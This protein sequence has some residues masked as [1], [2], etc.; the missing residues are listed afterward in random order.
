MVEGDVDG[1]L[2]GLADAGGD[3][4]LGR[5]VVADAVEALEVV[6]E[7]LSQLQE[8]VVRGVVGAALVQGA[9]G[10]LGEMAGRVEV[11]LADAEGDDVLH[12]ADE[13][14]EAADAGGGDALHA[15]GDELGGHGKLPPRR[16]GRDSAR[17]AIVGLIIA[18]RQR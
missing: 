12:A 16:P 2:E 18:K 15:A 17:P 1:E 3:H 14:E 10:G 13:V 5:R 4:D 9:D 8:A 6:G 11:G 7:G